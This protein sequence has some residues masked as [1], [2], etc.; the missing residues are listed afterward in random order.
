M[1]ST[2]DQLPTK[3]T[4]EAAPET[5]ESSDAENS[6]LAQ[7]SAAATAVAAVAKDDQGRNLLSYVQTNRQVFKA[8]A[9]LFSDPNLDEKKIWT[10][11]QSEPVGKEQYDCSLTFSDSI[12]VSSSS[13]RLP[14]TK[15]DTKH[16]PS[17]VS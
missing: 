13:R 9:N 6:S 10:D 8:A 4:T 17:F 7:D 2:L 16:P 15:R 3:S 12:F 5:P 1:I 14:T 11:N